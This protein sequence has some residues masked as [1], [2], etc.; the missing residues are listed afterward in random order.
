V[1]FGNFFRFM[2][3]QSVLSSRSGKQQADS[4]LYLPGLWK[5]CVKNA[6]A[7]GFAEIIFQTPSSGG[8]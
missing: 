1:E 7:I 6:T 2:A 3:I 4:A 8:E 5:F